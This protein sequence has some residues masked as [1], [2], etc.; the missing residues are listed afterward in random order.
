MIAFDTSLVVRI[1]TGDDP[2]QKAAALA[3]LTKE[4]V[5]VP[6]TVVLET[7]WVLRSR[8]GLAP[9]EVADFLTYLLESVSIVV[10]DAQTIHQ[11]LSKCP[12]R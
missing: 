3:L 5:F 10:E 8:Y 6:K 7:E 2:K 11:A 4:T 1:A 12:Y 9:Q